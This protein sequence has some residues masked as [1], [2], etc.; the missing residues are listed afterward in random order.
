[1]GF[2]L[3]L[4][5]VIGLTSCERDAAAPPAPVAAEAAPDFDLQRTDGTRVRLADLRGRW[6]LLD[7]WATWCPPCVDEIPELNAVWKRVSGRGVELL[8]V[9]V[10]ELELEALARWT[11]EHDVR[12]PVALAT[13]DL[14]VAYGGTEFPFHVLIDPDGQ[15]RERLPPGYHDR[16]ELL[17]LIE[18][19]R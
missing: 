5:V 12:Y 8:A 19:H 17:A 16:D 10:D 9:S 3:V 13:L 14:A 1:V 11:S 15:V 4:A 6:V 18:R 2:A 7:F